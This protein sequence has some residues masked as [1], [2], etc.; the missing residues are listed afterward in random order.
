MSSGWLSSSAITPSRASRATKHHIATMRLSAAPS[1]MARCGSPWDIGP[2]AVPAIS[3]TVDS[4]PTESSRDPH[5]GIGEQGGQRGPQTDDRGYAHH[6]GVGHALRNHV[7]RHG[8]PASRSAR[9]QGR[10]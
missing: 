10:R 9:S 6:R 1:A 5:E 7:C 8:N 2:M 3:A 4:G